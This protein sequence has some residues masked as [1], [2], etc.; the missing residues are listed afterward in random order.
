[1]KIWII[2][3]LL[4][5]L[6]VLGCGDDTTDAPSKEITPTLVSV[7]Q[8]LEESERE[9][10]ANTYASVYQFI[11]SLTSENARASARVQD[12]VSAIEAIASQANMQQLDE[13]IDNLGESSSAFRN[14]ASLTTALAYDSGD[15]LLAGEDEALALVES[16]LTELSTI[17]RAA[18]IFL[19]I[20]DDIGVSLETKARIGI[21]HTIFDEDGYILV[22]NYSLICGKK[23]RCHAAD[24]SPLP[25]CLAREP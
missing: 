7:T 16:I 6:V 18:D 19:E 2:A 9:G 4:I 15:A 5:A 23:W 11:G 10:C 12:V 25:M 20:A 17:R 22:R 21:L 14:I 13:I 24:S 8:T 3:V 1:M